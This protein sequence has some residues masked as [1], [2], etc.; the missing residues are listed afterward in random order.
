M[1]SDLRPNRR[2]V[3]SALAVLLGCCALASVRAAQFDLCVRGTSLEET[4][5]ARLQ[6]R[7]DGADVAAVA[8]ALGAAIANNRFWANRAEEVFGSSFDAEL[9]GDAVAPQLKFELALTAE[10]GRT[11]VAAIGGEQA[12]EIR[13]AVERV[14]GAPPAEQQAAVQQKELK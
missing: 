2:P 14:V 1:S 10:Q 13:A 12:G 11:L 4:R 9:C 3:T 8:P 5:T 7:I 6:L